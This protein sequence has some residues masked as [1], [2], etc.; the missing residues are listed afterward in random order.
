MWLRASHWR[1]VA[2]EPAD[3][4]RAHQATDDLE[5]AAPSDANE[6]DQTLSDHTHGQ[7][8]LCA[9]DHAAEH[10]TSELV[11]AEEKSPIRQGEWVLKVRCGVVCRG[12]PIGSQGHQCQ[13][14][15]GA[16]A[17]QGQGVPA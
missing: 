5:H 1:P 17:R 15:N 6:Q 7:R 9:V 14:H 11:R 3:R 2:G 12:E 13:Q 10:I 4:R 8:D 16:T